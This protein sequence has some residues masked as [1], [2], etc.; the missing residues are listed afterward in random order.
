MNIKELIKN[1]RSYRR[2]DNSNKIDMGF[3][4][5]M[6]YSARM[7]QSAA[8]LQP[9]RYITVTDEQ[10]AAEVYATLGWAGYLKDWDGPCEAERPVAYIVV[11]AAKDSP[12]AQVDAG[13]AMQNICLTAMSCDI[14]SCI[15]GNIDR[16]KLSEIIENKDLSILYV[17]ALGYPVENVKV[18]SVKDT[19]DHKYF[20]D[21]EGTHYV[22][23][24]CMEDIIIN[25]F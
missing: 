21:E 22:P 24:R 25:E 12:Y 13:L 18:V 10:K 9:L 8:N 4:E 5:D 2:F 3:L 20:R 6:L 15:L 23:K 17:I 16:A 1:N 11:L 19:G 14:G 7:S